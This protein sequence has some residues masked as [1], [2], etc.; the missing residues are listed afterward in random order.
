MSKVS[1]FQFSVF[2]PASFEMR[3][4]KSLLLLFVVVLVTAKRIDLDVTQSDVERILKSS[5]HQHQHLQRRSPP[6][7]IDID[8]V[9]QSSDFMT[10]SVKTGF[11]S[12]LMPKTPFLRPA[13]EPLSI[14]GRQRRQSNLHDTIDAFLIEYP[15]MGID[16]A[17]EQLQFKRR[18]DVSLLVSR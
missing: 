15:Q 13:N 10:T 2:P 17:Q 11:V 12:H 3:L 5:Q 8:I 4:F 14:K 1:L 9:R 18:H 16:N 6:N 7:S